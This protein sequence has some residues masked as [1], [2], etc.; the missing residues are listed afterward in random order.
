MLLLLPAPGRAANVIVG[1]HVLFPNT[2]LQ[3][4]TISITG[5]EQIAGE[6]F[7]AQVGDGGAFNGGVDTKPSISFATIASGTIFNGNTN[8]DFTDPGNGTTHPLIWV[9]GT[10]TNSGTVSANGTL[11]TILL[12]TTNLWSGT[13][14]LNLTNVASSHGSFNTT[15]R[16]AS[17]GIVPLSIINGSLI[18]GTPIAGDFDRNSVVDM[19]DYV[20]WRNGLG[21]TFTPADYDAWRSH[22]GQTL[23]LGASVG[24]G[25]AVPEPGAL[26]LLLAGISAFV[27]TRHRRAASSA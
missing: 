7:Y 20:M 14:A 16:D 5:G 8:G 12:D 11:A 26:L 27:G 1:T 22:Y 9:D 3:T 17:A 15:L 21:T 25:V 6:D 2:A 10:T 24:S 4:V 19:S 23:M 18:I 13:Y